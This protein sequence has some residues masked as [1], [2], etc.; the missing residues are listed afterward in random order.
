MIEPYTITNKDVTDKIFV[1]FFDSKEINEQYEEEARRRQDQAERG[2][3][4]LGVTGNDH[5]IIR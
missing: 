3:D 1:E 2:I 5:R 4:K